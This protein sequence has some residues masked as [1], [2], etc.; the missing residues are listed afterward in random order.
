LVLNKGVLGKEEID[1]S[2]AKQVL[3]NFVT[4]INKEVTPEVIQRTVADY[5]DLDVEK[6]ASATRRRQVVLARQISMFLVKEYTDQSLKAIGRMFGGRDHS[7]VLYSIKTV[8]DLMETNDEIKKALGELE[9]KIR[10]G[11]GDGELV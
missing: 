3:K 1:L 11:Q 2:L 10:I 8:K 9:R 6:L 4:E 7:T 5:Y